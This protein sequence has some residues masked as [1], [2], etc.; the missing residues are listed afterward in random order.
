MTSRERRAEASVVSEVYVAAMTSL[1]IKAL[2]EAIILWGDVVAVPG[3]VAAS[4]A[5]WLDFALSLVGTRRAHAR[6]LTIAYYRLARALHTGTSIHNP[7]A[8]GPEPDSVPLNELRDD[9][10]NLVDALAPEV[11]D[12]TDEEIPGEHADSVQSNDD[13]PPAPEIEDEELIELERLDRLAEE[14]EAIEDAAEE[15]AR[16]VLEALGPN[17]LESKLTIIHDDAPAKT[18]DKQREIA[19]VDAGNQQAAAAQRVVMNGGRA[20]LFAVAEQDPKAIGFV[21]SSRTGTPCGWCAMLISRGL[22]LYKSEH[23]AQFTDDGDRYHD[24]C[25][26][27]AIPVFSEEHYNEDPQFDLNREYDEL[28]P[29][30]TDGYEGDEALSVWRRYFRQKRQEAQAA[31]AETPRTVQEAA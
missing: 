12:H 23:S 6:T 31:E 10:F 1:G 16:I 22:V 19:R 30:V 5:R 18:V 27:E 28:W 13:L 29:K 26:C 25:N 24:N 21:R 14:I 3:K 7:F 17:N 2:G 20:P 8:E 11:M 15:E 4:G 9:F